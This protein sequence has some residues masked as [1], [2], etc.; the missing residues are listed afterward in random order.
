MKTAA[1]AASQE[2]SMSLQK[3]NPDKTP[4]AQDLFT[5]C[6]REKTDTWHIVR[7]HDGSGTV[8]RVICK[9][10]GSEHKYR[11]QTVAAAPKATK[12]RAVVRTTASGRRVATSA[13]TSA[14]SD[15]AIRDTWFAGLKK[16]GSKD[17]GNFDINKGY[18]VGEVFEHAVFG[19]G[20]VQT[21]RENKIDVL[22]VEGLK[23]LPSPRP[24][25][26]E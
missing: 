16:W 13:I 20:V 6:T 22:F 18:L 1:K 25:M 10:C 12:T 26:T 15:E 21:R 23:T 8:D 17:I 9:A 2:A 7:N 14:S 11:K 5:Y 24:P 3:T 4:V 19:K